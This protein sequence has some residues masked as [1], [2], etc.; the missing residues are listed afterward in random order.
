MVSVQHLINRPHNREEGSEI[1]GIA[2]NLGAFYPKF[3]HC[4][5]THI[6]VT[7]VTI[8]FTVQWC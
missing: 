3:F 6:K 7:T 8:M 4:G 1:S 5:K 2:S